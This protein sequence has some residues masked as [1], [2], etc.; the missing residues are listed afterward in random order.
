MDILRG[1]SEEVHNDAAKVAFLPPG[2]ELQKQDY[3][4]FFTTSALYS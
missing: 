3:L 4:Y 2:N 1:Q